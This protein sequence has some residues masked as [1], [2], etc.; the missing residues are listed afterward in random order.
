MENN[1]TKET[2]LEKVAGA[3]A[4]ATFWM[5]TASPLACLY[6]GKPDL[7]MPAM[8]GGYA[9]SGAVALLVEANETQKRIDS[10]RA[11]SS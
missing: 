8:I 11:Y 10:E 7:A 3:V 2:K 6:L 4:G 9:L 1:R 5:A